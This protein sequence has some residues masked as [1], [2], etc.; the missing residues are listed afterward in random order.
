MVELKDRQQQ[1]TEGELRSHSCLML[2]AQF[3]ISCWI[4]LYLPSR[5]KRSSDVW[6]AH[7]F[8]SSQFESLYVGTSYINRIF[9][10]TLR[11]LNSM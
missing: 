5:K 9:D 7:I 11:P 1:E 6:V 4:L 10:L 3:L 8:E 2:K